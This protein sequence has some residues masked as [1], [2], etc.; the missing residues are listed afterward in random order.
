MGSQRHRDDLILWGK[1]INVSDANSY[2]IVRLPTWT[3]PAHL[4]SDGADRPLPGVPSDRTARDLTKADLV[5]CVYPGCGPYSHVAGTEKRRAGFVHHSGKSTRDHA[6]GDES[7]DHLN[8]KT[9]L[10]SWILSVYGDE[11]IDHDL[12]SKNIKKEASADI[13][14]VGQVRPDAWVKFKNGQQIAIEFQHSVGDPKRVVDKT[15]AYLQ[16]DITPWWVFSG[17]SSET[18]VNVR[19]A[20]FTSHYGNLVADLSA[21]QKALTDAGVLFFWFDY[22]SARLATPVVYSQVSF[23]AGAGE[24]W[25]RQALRTRKRYVR[26]P[27]RYLN[28]WARIFDHSLEECAV[29]VSTGALVTPG[30]RAIT[31]D[32]QRI[33]AEIQELRAQARERF[34]ETERQRKRKDAAA[35]MQLVEESNEARVPIGEASREPTGGDV[36]E[37]G[38]YSSE[39]EVCVVSRS[40]AAGA[41]FVR[42]SPAIYDEPTIKNASGRQVQGWGVWRKLKQWF[43]W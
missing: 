13:G 23:R 11:I 31:R 33:A 42:E 38:T 22:E 37:T 26:S 21:P 19:P 6:G 14:V 32:A 18:C 39:P 5:D 29:D 3:G 36:P 41:D 28:S 40:P 25:G 35:Q 10:L 34:Q 9:A 43:T 12:D 27:R 17:R 8:S 24:L 16:S 15:K 20:K 1:P 30:T 4:P 7:L 2:G